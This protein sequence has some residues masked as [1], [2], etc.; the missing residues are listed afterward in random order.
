MKLVPMQWGNERFE[1]LQVRRG[2]WSLIGHN[3]EVFATSRGWGASVGHRFLGYYRH[4]NKAMEAVVSYIAYEK[5]LR[6]FG[7]KEVA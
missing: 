2:C 7:V 6:E 3:A 1:W 4:R 5:K